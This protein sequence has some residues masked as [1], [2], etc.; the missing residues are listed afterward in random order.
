MMRKKDVKLIAST[1]ADYLDTGMPMQDSVR[2]L[3]RAI[4]KYAGIFK[5][6]AE[7]LKNGTPLSR[8]ME[9]Y[10]DD[11]FL[12]V[13]RAGE[14]SGDLAKT[15]RDIEE[16]I[17]IEMAV[18]K[19]VGR[20]Y[21]PL[22]M[23]VAGLSVGFMFMIFVVPGIA[24]SL[25][26][27]ENPIILFSLALS[28]SID[29][30]Y[31]YY[32]IGIFGVVTAIVMFLRS[33]TGK[34]IIFALVTSV[35]FLREPVVE[36]RFGVW[37]RYMAM[38][39]AAGIG[40][41]D[42]LKMTEDILPGELRKAINKVRDDLEN[43]IAMQDAVDIERLPKNDPRHQYMP[44]FIINSFVTA[45]QTGKLDIALYKSSPTLIKQ[46]KEK[47]ERIVGIG[48]AIAIGVSAFVIIAPLGV[49][50]GELFKALDN[51]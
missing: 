11:S 6:M 44:F 7:A 35:K 46:G 34:E 18:Q 8:L 15:M 36:L 2:R 3:D 1:L 30:N 23:M 20:I 9:G 29:V 16:S 12:T 37:A 43:N 26:E 45:A 49:I 40:T 48:R 47:I 32:V 42:A 41:R 33:K 14:E 50:Y 22:G 31:P 28:E 24:A 5:E 13:M 38:A 19:E 4:P 21:Y 27:I 51:I 10:F 25:E 39:V 17:E